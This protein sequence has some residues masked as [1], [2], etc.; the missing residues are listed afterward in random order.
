MSMKTSAFVLIAASSLAL[1]GGPATAATNLG[2]CATPGVFDTGFIYHDCAGAYSGNV[3][4]NNNRS[5]AAQIDALNTLGVDTTN[6]DYNTFFKISSLG[7]G[8]IVLPGGMEMIGETVFGI[9]FGGSSV[10]GNATA[11]YKFDA[12]TGL[13]GIPIATSGSS[14][15]VLYQTGNAQPGP[16][17]T[18]GAV[19]EPAGWALLVA[20][21]GMIGVLARRRRRIRKQTRA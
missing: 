7:G 9:H 19:P 20:G 17:D 3:L 21:F 6:F 4:S 13:T 16:G 18:A 12:G 10:L 5:V 8:D 11:F 14:G 15:F 2:N 1:A